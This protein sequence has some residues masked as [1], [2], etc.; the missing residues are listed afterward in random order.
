M[1]IT[2]HV[3]KRAET[4]LISGFKVVDEDGCCVGVVSLSDVAQTDTRALAG[5]VLYEITRREARPTLPGA[6]AP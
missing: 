2:G 5:H 3:V 1:V 4:L 6:T